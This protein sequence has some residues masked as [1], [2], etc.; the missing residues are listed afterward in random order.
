MITNRILLLEII[1][2][3]GRFINH[4]QF[5]YLFLYILF[6]I[7]LFGHHISLKLSTTFVFRIAIFMKMFS[8]YSLYIFKYFPPANL[9]STM[10]YTYTDPELLEVM[11]LYTQIA[12][13]LQEPQDDCKL[14]SFK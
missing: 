12:R 8:E 4:F 6:G 9:I 14:Q 11:P 3:L 7:L 2:N 5:V 13:A 1:G 10:L